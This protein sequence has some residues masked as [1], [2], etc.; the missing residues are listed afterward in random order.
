LRRQQALLD[1]IWFTDEDAD[2]LDRVDAHD[3]KAY[4]ERSARLRANALLDHEVRARWKDVRPE[5]ANVPGLSRCAQRMLT[6]IHDAGRIVQASGATWAKVL[7]Y[8][9]SS[10]WEAVWQLRERGFAWRLRDRK[11]APWPFSLKYTH[12][13]TA[14]LYVLGW[15]AHLAGLYWPSVAPVDNAADKAEW[16][17]I[18]LPLSSL[19]GSGAQRSDS[20]PGPVNLWT[21][22]LALVPSEA[23]ASA[24]GEEEKESLLVDSS[25]R[26]PSTLRESIEAAPP[27]PERAARRDLR[28]RPL[29]SSSPAPR[30]RRR[31][32]KHRWRGRGLRAPWGRGARHRRPLARMEYPEPEGGGS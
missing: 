12:S 25:L 5:R 19:S 29:L 17:P 20:D 15:A 7:R 11:E 24:P 10:V 14:N 4:F 28:R 23:E 27:A 13:N 16:T 9:E 3:C 21:T 2:H 32:K 18:V 26:S 22:R 1:D 31:R 30:R 8:G 6:A